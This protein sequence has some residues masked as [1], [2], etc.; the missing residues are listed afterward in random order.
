MHWC[1]PTFLVFGEDE[2]RELPQGPR[3]VWASEWVLGQFRL[4]VK[5]K[6]EEE[7]VFPWNLRGIPL[8]CKQNLKNAISKGK[9]E[10]GPSTTPQATPSA[11]WMLGSIL[12]AIAKTIPT[13]GESNKY[14]VEWALLRIWLPPGPLPPS[15]SQRSERFLSN[16]NHLKKVL[17]ATAKSHQCGTLVSETDSWKA[18]RVDS[19]EVRWRQADARRES[20]GPDLTSDLTV[21]GPFSGKSKSFVLC[22]LQCWLYGHHDLP[23]LKLSIFCQRQ[24]SSLHEGGL[25]GAFALSPGQGTKKMN[26]A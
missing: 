16:G 6:G 13:D 5:K 18:I 14:G 25:F 17:V 4:Q 20:K 12:T 19:E 8:F 26:K 7:K 21:P 2:A 1:I 11:Q 24:T 15:F 10:T 23:N 3:P 9:K 22:R